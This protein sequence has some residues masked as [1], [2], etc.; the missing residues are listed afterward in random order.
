[1]IPALMHE[2]MRIQHGRSYYH[3][4][5]IRG[6]VSMHLQSIDAHNCGVA[7]IFTATPNLPLAHPR[8]SLIPSDSDDLS[9]QVLHHEALRLYKCGNAQIHIVSSSSSTQCPSTPI[10]QKMRYK[11]L[12]TY[13]H[14][15][16]ESLSRTLQAQVFLA[17][18]H[19]ERNIR[20][21]EQTVPLGA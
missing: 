16:A 5:E 13:V 7:G 8:C 15:G 17:C 4:R 19:W 6:T 10:I 12:H 1:M 20:I 2:A 9:A 18:T 11:G 21:C 14:A 3:N